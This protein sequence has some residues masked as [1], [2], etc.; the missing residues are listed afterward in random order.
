VVTPWGNTN[1]GSKSSFDVV[2]LPYNDY[3][4]VVMIQ[5][6]SDKYE[7]KKKRIEYQ[8]FDYVYYDNDVLILIKK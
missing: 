2:L 6:I 7:T 4:D 5:K 8:L 1:V 3:D